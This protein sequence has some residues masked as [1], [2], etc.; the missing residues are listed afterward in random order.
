MSLEVVRN[1][2]RHTSARLRRATSVRIWSQ[3][4]SAVREG[5]NPAIKPPISPVYQP[6]A[7][8]LPIITRSFDQPLATPTLEAP[9]AGERRVKG[10]LH[11]ILEIQVGSRQQGEQ[12]WQIRS[13][14][15]STGRGSDAVVPANN[16]STRSLFPRSP[17]SLQLCVATSRSAACRHC[18]AHTS[19]HALSLA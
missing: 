9:D 12:V 18:H 11:L 4:T 19:R 8:H 3:K 2:D 5:G 16:A 1:D 6:K 7:V 13:T 17:L 15:G 14:N 10:K